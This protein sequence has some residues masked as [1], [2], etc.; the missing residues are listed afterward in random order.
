MNRQFFYL[1]ASTLLAFAGCQQNVNSRL[2][3]KWQLKTVEH[4]GIVTSVDTVWYNFQSE[5]LFM[6]QVFYAQKDSFMYRY[7]YA[8][9]PEESVLNLELES[10]AGPLNTFLPYTDWRDYKRT[11]SIDKIKGKQ[12]VLRDQDKIYSFKKFE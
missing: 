6:Y 2:Q 5:S 9:Y 12:L 4:E 1:I 7:G 11:F 10:Y 8:T 3:G